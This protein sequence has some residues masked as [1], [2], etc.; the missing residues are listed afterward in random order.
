MLKLHL[1]PPPPTPMRIA[2]DGETFTIQARALTIRDAHFV[3]EIGAEFT[4]R[5][6]S[7]NNPAR[8]IASILP[9]FSVDERRKI[10]TSAGLS[11]MGGEDV[12]S[13]CD[14]AENLTKVLPAAALSEIAKLFVILQEASMPEK[15]EGV[16]P[17]SVGKKLRAILLTVLP[18]ALCAFFAYHLTRYLI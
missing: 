17:V 4:R 15:E 6:L 16:S 12:L 2:A 14:A 7:D 8:Y 5:E 11:A 10:M 13:Y 3:A 9:Q 1:V 18:C